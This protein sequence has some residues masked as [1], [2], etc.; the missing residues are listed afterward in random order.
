MPAP[1]VP[2]A[3]FRAREQRR[4]EA[5]RALSVRDEEQTQVRR[6]VERAGRDDPG[7]SDHAAGVVRDE[8]DVALAQGLA[9][10]GAGAGGRERV[11]A[12]QRRGAHEPGE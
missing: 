12:E 8:D 11:P 1:R 6:S 2:R 5:A 9:E 3:T 4:A 7:E 10:R